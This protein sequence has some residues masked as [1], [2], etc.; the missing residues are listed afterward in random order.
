[1]PIRAL[2]SSLIDQIAAGE[3]VERPASV[4]KELIENSLDAG[5]TRIDVEVD[6]GGIRRILVRD[7]GSGIDAQELPLALARHATSKIATLDDLEKVATLGFRGEALP[8]MASVARLTLTSRAAG[9]DSGWQLAGHAAAESGPVPAP[10]PPGTSVEVCDL[11]FN[12]PARRKFLRTEKT[13]YGHLEKLFRRM[14]LSRFDVAWKLTHNRRE[15]FSLPLADT[16]EAREKRIARLC[17][18]PFV[19]SVMHIDH[20]AAGFELHGWIA[21]P[22]FSRSQ[23]DLQYFFLNGR[24]V[25]D[26][27]VRH[28]VRHAYRDVLFHGRHPAYLLYLQ[29]DP[30][31]VDVNAHPAKHEVRFRDG[32]SV[33]GFVSQTVEQALAQTSPGRDELA[34]AA[35]PV[36]ARGQMSP[37]AMTTHRGHGEARFAASAAAGNAPRRQSSLAIHE[38]ISNYA[39][40][41]ERAAEHRDEYPLGTALAQL[42]GIYILAQTRDGLIIVDMHAAHERIVYEGLKATALPQSQPLLVPVEVTVSQAEADL[43]ERYSDQFDAIGVAIDRGGPQT[44]LIREVPVLLA[45]ADVGQLIRDLLSDLEQHGSSQRLTTFR[46][47][48]LA[49]MACHGSVR[50]HR[51]LSLEEMNALLRQMENT[52]RADQCNH[53]RPT[54]MRLT[55]PELD[56]LF[57]RGQ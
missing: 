46:D 54:W 14:A 41:H 55:L 33:H 9:A 13:E 26:K 7:N 12:V 27:V 44:L 48:V 4:L 24:Y 43:I 10:H 52:P 50:A 22:T 8:S 56:R 29:M 20:A 16:R 1:M 34:P 49:T 42:H 31:Q 32:R 25:Q 28:A 23:A 21:L 36:S 6:G 47:H 51:D 53:G 38:Q 45:N 15:I 57:L 17:G 39:R 5:A 2:P 30:V 3:V 18:D 19:S 40:L 37:A 35:H 11:F